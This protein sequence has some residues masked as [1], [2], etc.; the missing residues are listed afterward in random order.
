MSNKNEKYANLMSFHPHTVIY[1]HLIDL[2]LYIG[3]CG[4]LLSILLLPASNA[5]GLSSYRHSVWLQSRLRLFLRDGD[6]IN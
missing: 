3:I 4:F 1:T 2:T 5:G 6:L